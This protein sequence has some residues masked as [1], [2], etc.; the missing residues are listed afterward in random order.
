MLDGVQV[1]LQPCG[2]PAQ[3]RQEPAQSIRASTR[4][5]LAVG[6]GISALSWQSAS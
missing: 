1:G 5:V 2:R 4:W 6:K 3:L